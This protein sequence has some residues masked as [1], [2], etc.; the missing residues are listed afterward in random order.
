MLMKAKGVDAP[1]EVLGTSQCELAERITV[2]TNILPQAEIT[3]SKE[4][5]HQH[6]G[7]LLVYF[8]NTC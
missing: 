1:K 2:S 4:H 6:R 8:Q 5:P 3:A 7:Q